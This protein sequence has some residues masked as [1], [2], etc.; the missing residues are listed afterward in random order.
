MKLKM[1][2][3][4]HFTPKYLNKHKIVIGSL[5][6][7]NHDVKKTFGS[8]TGIPEPG[9]AYTF[10]VSQPISGY[11]EASNVQDMETIRSG[12]PQRGTHDEDQ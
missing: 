3:L 2:A 8:R 11:Q 5:K 6:L 1:E 7:L 9:D 4:T 10:H 12:I